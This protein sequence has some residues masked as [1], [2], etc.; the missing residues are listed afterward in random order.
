[1]LMQPSAMHEFIEILM[2]VAGPFLRTQQLCRL[3]IRSQEMKLGFPKKFG[4]TKSTAMFS[5]SV[6]DV[7]Q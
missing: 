1:M 3:L 5:R 7:T 2:I 4:E 6:I